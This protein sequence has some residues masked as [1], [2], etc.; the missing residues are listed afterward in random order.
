MLLEQKSFVF[1][2]S[3]GGELCSVMCSKIWM[4]FLRNFSSTLL[5]SFKIFPKTRRRWNKMSSYSM[6]S[7]K[8]VRTGVASFSRLSMCNISFC[9]VSKNLH[10]WI[11]M[12]RFIKIVQTSNKSSGNI[13]SFPWGNFGRGCWPSAWNRCIR[14]TRES[15]WRL[16]CSAEIS[17]KRRSWN[18]WYRSLL[19]SL[20]FL[21][22][23]GSN[24]GPSS[25]REPLEIKWQ[26]IL[27]KAL[28]L[29]LTTELSS[30]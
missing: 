8:R 2:S 20:T 21:S 15:S 23:S 22:A 10:N 18:S 3:L 14:W 13:C 16:I 6:N 9:N 27:S 11:F 30:L 26:N 17:L 19:H 1:S 29:A 5:L 12:Y 4:R 25:H 28:I 7:W 24:C